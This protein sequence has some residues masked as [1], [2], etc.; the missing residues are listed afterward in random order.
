MLIDNPESN[1]DRILRRIDELETEKAEA[2]LQAGTDATEKK[3][4]ILSSVK[5]RI[6]KYLPFR[7]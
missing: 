3:L 4:G 6:R 5:E 2:E 7:S 1:I